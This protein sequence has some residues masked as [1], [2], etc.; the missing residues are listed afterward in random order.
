MQVLQ[1]RN[2]LAKE[3]DRL[4]FLKNELQENID[5]FHK[6]LK[7]PQKVTVQDV[8]FLYGTHTTLFSRIEMKNEEVAFID[9]TLENQK[10]LLLGAYQKKKV[11]EVF[12]NKMI[13]QEKRE[14]GTGEQRSMDFLNL[15]KGSKK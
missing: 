13:R 15:T 1:T 7:E 9:K 14:E 10:A 11:F 2:R 4:V 12:R 3:K 5:D 8:T 6:R